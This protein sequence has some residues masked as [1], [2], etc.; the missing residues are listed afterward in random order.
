MEGGCLA[1]A[2]STAIR[3]MAL[4]SSS[5]G[6][7]GWVAGSRCVVSLVNDRATYDTDHE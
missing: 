5:G 1:N 6:S 4:W 7:L 2:F 3:A